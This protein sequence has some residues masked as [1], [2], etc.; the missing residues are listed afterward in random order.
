MSLPQDI[1]AI[2]KMLEKHHGKAFNN[3]PWYRIAWSESMTEKRIG[4]FNDF[5]GEIFLRQFV[6]LREVRKYDG[7]DFRERWILEKLVFIDNPEVW[8]S[9]N[10]GSYE[11]IWVFRGKGGVYQRPNHKAVEF[12]IGMIN[13]PEERKFHDEKSLDD[14]EE[15]LL[16][17]ETD[18]LYDEM[19]QNASMFDEERT[20]VVPSNYIGRK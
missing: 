12:L 7:P 14:F 19:T 1:K 18:Q 9:L 13:N 10:S 4:A 20:I 17:D 5:Y 15:Q 3:K 6:G 2:N 11:P 8:D 16:A